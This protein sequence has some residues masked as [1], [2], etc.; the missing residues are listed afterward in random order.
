M[1]ALDHKRISV[2]PLQLNLT[3]QGLLEDLART[4]A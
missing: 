1:A 2:T 3:H 4:L